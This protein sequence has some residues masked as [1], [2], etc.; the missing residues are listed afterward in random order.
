MGKKLPEISVE[1]L[2]EYMGQRVADMDHLPQAVFDD[3]A[4]IRSVG[5]SMD[6]AISSLSAKYIQS[7][8]IGRFFVIDCLKDMLENLEEEGD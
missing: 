5:V 6:N 2:L 4:C 7:G 3:I 1:E 8:S